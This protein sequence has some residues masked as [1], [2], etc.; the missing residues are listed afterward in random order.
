MTLTAPSPAVTPTRR[1]RVQHWVLGCSAVA[2]LPM[3]AVHLAGAERVDPIDQPISHYAFVPTGYEMILLGSVLL[4]VAALAIGTAIA[5]TARRAQRSGRAGLIA[6]ALLLG[7]FVVAMMLVGV[8]PTDRPGTLGDP[9]TSAL[10][11]RWAASYAFAVMP[12]IGLLVS[13]SRMITVRQRRQLRGLSLAVLAGTALVFAIHFPLAAAGSHIPMFGL[14]ERIGFVVMVAFL[15]VLSGML[16]PV[17]P[18]DL[19]PTPARLTPGL[20]P[21]H[22]NCSASSNQA[23]SKVASSSSAVRS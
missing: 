18:A 21:N 16:R 20:R 13:R 2:L 7:T 14:I 22:S 12:I 6:P 3:V 10:I 4:A 19:P 11:H 15:V 5:R 8:F 23:V 1:I 17:Q 9:S